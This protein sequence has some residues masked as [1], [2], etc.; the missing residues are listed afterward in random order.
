[1]RSNRLGQGIGWL[2]LVGLIALDTIGWPLPAS[3]RGIMRRILMIAALAALAGCT[4]EKGATKALHD[5]GLKPVSVG[6][7]AWFYCA[8]G[9]GE[10]RRLRHEVYG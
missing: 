5:T 9:R 6:G 1:M 4:D 2:G 8:V 10:R 7:H 3:G